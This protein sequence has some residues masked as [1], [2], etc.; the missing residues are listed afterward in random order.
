MH[1]ATS[2][3][4]GFFVDSTK[5]HEKTIYR[6]WLH[7]FIIT[8]ETLYSEVQNN[9]IFSQVR[10]IYISLMVASNGMMYVADADAAI[11]GGVEHEMIF[12]YNMLRSRMETF[13]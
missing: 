11:H 9:F 10:I 8:H 13:G 12:L 7:V 1:S 2:P 4:F 6:V 5:L 3:T